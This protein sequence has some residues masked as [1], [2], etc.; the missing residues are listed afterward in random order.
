V[1]TVSRIERDK[2][3]FVDAE[4]KEVDELDVKEG[5]VKSFQGTDVSIQADTICIHG[6]S[7][8]AIDFAKYISSAL[9]K[10]NIKVANIST[11]AKQVFLDIDNT[12]MGLT[13]K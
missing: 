9:K 13:P 6:D 4:T 2:L 1:R 11:F 10:A 5:K 12:N 3:L 8:S 7:K